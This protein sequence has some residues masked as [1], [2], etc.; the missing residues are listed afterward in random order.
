MDSTLYKYMLE[1]TREAE[2]NSARCR[3]TA[4]TLCVHALL[5]IP[6]A[7]IQVLAQLRIETHEKHT[8]GR[9]M[10]ITPGRLGRQLERFFPM[11]RHVWACCKAK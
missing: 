6:L 9:H 4:A 5:T 2:V 1:H 8:L 10:Q 7:P 3:R 11:I